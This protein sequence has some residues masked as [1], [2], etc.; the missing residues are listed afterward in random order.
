MCSDVI[1]ER[2]TKDGKGLRTGE[3]AELG[4]NGDLGKEG[5]WEENPRRNGKTYSIG[6]EVNSCQLRL[7]VEYSANEAGIL[8]KISSISH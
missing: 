6:W 4:V 7:E 3:E 8:T 2:S 5:V 1:S